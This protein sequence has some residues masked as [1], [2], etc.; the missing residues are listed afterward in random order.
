MLFMVSGQL[1]PEENFPLLGLE[2]WSRLEL[3]LGLGGNQTIA[4]KKSVPWL[5]LGFWLG[6]V[7]ALEGNFVRGQ[8]SW[9]RFSLVKI[10]STFT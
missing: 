10:Q 7:L 6:L 9:N 3:V 1:P 2:F 4:P 8:L 5:G